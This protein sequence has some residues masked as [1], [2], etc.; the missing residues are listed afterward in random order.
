MNKTGIMAP[1]NFVD[2]S[3]DDTSGCWLENDKFSDDVEVNMWQAGHNCS[4][5]L[6]DSDFVKS[7][8][9]TI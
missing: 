6:L 1:T 5:P 3:L 2:D 8:K 9:N 7:N 4:I